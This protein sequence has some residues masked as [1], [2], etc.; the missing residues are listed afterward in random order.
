MIKLVVPK[1]I[2]EPFKQL[3][4]FKE[5]SIAIL[6]DSLISKNVFM[7]FWNCPK[8]NDEIWQPW[9]HHWVI[10][11]QCL[12]WKIKNLDDRQVFKRR[13]LLM[14]TYWIETTMPDGHLNGEQLRQFN[15]ENF[16]DVYGGKSRIPQSPCVTSYPHMQHRAKQ[17]RM[18][19]VWKV[20]ILVSRFCPR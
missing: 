16:R 18:H 15:V 10:L 1:A 7:N 17:V 13:S 8:E 14:N 3:R 2:F 20:G 9:N 6:M 5:S 19:I 4:A 11:W 12:S